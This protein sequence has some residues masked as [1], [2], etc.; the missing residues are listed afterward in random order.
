M[1][2]FS[3]FLNFNGLPMMKTVYLIILFYFPIFLFAQY[4]PSLKWQKFYDN[5]GVDIPH[6]II[7]SSDN[8]LL[9]GG[10]TI[11]EDS[12]ESQ[13]GDIWIIKVDTLG[14]LIWE[15]E[16]AVSGCEELRDMVASDDGGLIFTGVTTSLI[17]HTE[18]GNEDYWGDYFVG[19]VDSSGVVEWLQSYGGSNLD[20]AFALAKGTYR[21]YMVVGSSHS[22]DGDPKT[23]NGMS[24]VWALK[25]DTKGQKRFS[26]IIGGSQNDW[27]TAITQCMNG[28]YL[29]A[30]YSN[31]PELGEQALSSYGN[32]LLVRM[33]QSGYVLWSRTFPCAKGGYFSDVLEVNDGEIILTGYAK[34][35]SNGLDF[36]WLRLTER[37]QIILEKKLPGPQD[38]ILTSVTSCE[39]GG[40]LVAGYSLPKNSRGIYNKGGE[41]FWLLR[42]DEKGNIIWKNTYGGPDDERCMDVLEYKPGVIY[43]VGKKFNRFNPHREANHDYWLIRLEEFPTDSI[44]ANI[45]VRADDYR[46][47]RSTP[48]R[49]RARYNYGER[50]LWDF[51]DGTTSTE[52]N[53]LKTYDYSG[54]YEVKLTVYVNEN[55]FETVRLD[56][57]LEVW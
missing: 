4:F 38:E 2:D 39:S 15:R 31:S 18:H 37:G 11:V 47:N 9:I 27:A 54:V 20:Q 22:K 41:D 42:F 5:M 1:I 56:R 26:Q 19:K 49:F 57:L 32:G 36:W 35:P 51:G 23:N 10:K 48:T 25:I 34:S 8:Q 17:Q 24:D 29:L 6:K 50:F 40:T 55:C 30:G 53:P 13:C 3:L 21:E 14:E 28:D 44:G 16:I 52:P 45:Y 12:L 33:S 46:I 43:A 7:K